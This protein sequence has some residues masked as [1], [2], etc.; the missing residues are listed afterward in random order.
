MLLKYSTFWSLAILVLFQTDSMVL[1]SGGA[2]LPLYVDSTEGQ[3]NVADFYMDIY[4]VTNRDF[5]HFL[6]E[7]PQW[8]PQNIPRLFAEEGYL[9]DFDSW[10]QHYPMA[11]VTQVSWYAAQAYCQCQGK[12]LPTQDEWEYVALANQQKSDARDSEDFQKNILKWYE[13][14]KKSNLK[15]GSTFVNYWGISDMHGLIWEWTFDFNAVLLSGESRK[16]G[17]VDRNL[18]CGGA[19]LGATD[20][21]DYAAFIRYAF[22]GSLQADYCIQNLGF[23]CVKSKE[24]EVL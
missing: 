23:R 2:Y 24:N 18:F 21:G 5:A 1:V 16:D 22:R 10:L 7:N 3:I 13:N 20:M 11:A 8:K 15:V 9:K 6:E 12:R 17:Q 14:P 4:P 19:S